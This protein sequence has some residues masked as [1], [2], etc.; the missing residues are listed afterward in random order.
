MV[1]FTRKHFTD[2]RMSSST[3]LCGTNFTQICLFPKYS[4]GVWGKVPWS[5]C[6]WSSIHFRLMC[7]SL[8]T[9]TQTFTTASR[10][11]AVDGCPLLGLS[12]R[13][14]H[15][16]WIFKLGDIGKRKS[17]ISINSFK[18]SVCFCICLPQVW[19]KVDVCSC[20]SNVFLMRLISLNSWTFSG[21]ILTV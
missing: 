3:R 2:G 17:F 6:S 10:C 7:W 9:I 12:S 4:W 5:M 1:W 19:N 16:L 21:Q 14:C 18:H 15:F 20:C 11:Q 8:A 13:P